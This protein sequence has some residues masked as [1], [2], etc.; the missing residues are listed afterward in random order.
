MD[1][2]NSSYQ[3]IKN[4]LS[5]PEENQELEKII[6]R[7]DFSDEFE[8]EILNAIYKYINYF[9]MFNTIEPFMK[10]LF[11]IVKKSFEFNIKSV[12]DFQE[13]LIK[14]TLTRLIQEYLTYSKTHQ[15]QKVLS[16]LTDSLQKLQLQPLIINL[17]LLIK[18]MYEDEEY[19]EKIEDFEEVE[20]TYALNDE[21]EIQIKKEVDKWLEEQEISLKNQDE[22]EQRLDEK[23]NTLINECGI[24]VSS[25]KCNKLRTE[26][27]EM[28]R[29]KLT[30]VSLMDG[31]K[32]TEPE[33][34]SIK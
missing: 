32:E 2:I 13:I 17:G 23:F 19:V 27:I 4:F 24:D 33:P 7:M 22:L 29:M 14:T 30:V 26:V 15:E 28:L 10:S 8:L 9:A 6:E 18:P 3:K 12:E 1:S 5:V 25:E 21:E 11:I 20:V 34:I 31:L 16:Y